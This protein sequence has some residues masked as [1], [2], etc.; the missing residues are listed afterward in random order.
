M[1]LTDEQTKAKHNQLVQVTK[2]K[3]K[4]DRDENV[5]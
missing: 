2:K 3:Y 1:L 4:L 5:D